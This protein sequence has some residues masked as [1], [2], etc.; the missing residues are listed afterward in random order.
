MILSVKYGA[1]NTPRWD[2]IQNTSTDEMCRISKIF[3]YAGSWEVI[4]TR[5]IGLENDTD[6]WEQKG[7]TFLISWAI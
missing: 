2:T 7:M 1:K 3:L 4:K 5:L 6:T